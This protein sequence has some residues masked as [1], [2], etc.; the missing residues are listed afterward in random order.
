MQS[1]IRDDSL[2]QQVRT[3]MLRKN[4]T[5]ISDSLHALN[6]GFLPLMPT[7]SEFWDDYADVTSPEADHLHFRAFSGAATEA[8]SVNQVN[9]H[10]WN[11]QQGEFNLTCQNGNRTSRG[12]CFTK[13]AWT[14]MAVKNE[15]RGTTFMVTLRTPAPEPSE[16]VTYECL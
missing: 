14:H 7:Q 11:I 8:T 5:G 16:C 15:S 12:C 10:C 13:M 2:H 6:I 4:V 9:D 3:V 1:L